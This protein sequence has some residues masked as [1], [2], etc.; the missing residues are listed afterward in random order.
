MSGNHGEELEDIDAELEER[1]V[2]GG[3][4]CLAATAFIMDCFLFFDV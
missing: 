2:T 4:L 1:T 3:L